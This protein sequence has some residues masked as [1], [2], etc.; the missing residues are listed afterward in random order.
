[1][2]ERTVMLVLTDQDGLD[3][4]TTLID[5]K[6][7]L[8]TD[9]V[10]PAIKAACKDFLNTQEGKAAWEDTC[11]NFNYGDFNTYVGNKFCEPHGF[12]KIEEEYFEVIDADFNEQLAEPDDIPEGEGFNIDT[13]FS[14]IVVSGEDIDDIME[15]AMTGCT[16][17]CEKAEV[18]GDYRGNYANEQISRDGELKFYPVDDE[19]VIL[20]KEKF[21][22]GLNQWLKELWGVNVEKLR[23]ILPGGMLDPGQI[24]AADA[25]TIIQYALFDEL[26]Y[27]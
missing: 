2:E 11:H 18:I 24:D 13:P 23:T 15:S 7:A 17:W 21:R 9:Q 20:D 6:T 14:L 12:T 19:P 1:M 27:S 5:I 26:V 16:Y 10:I 22:S 25:D 3:V 4:R 8:P